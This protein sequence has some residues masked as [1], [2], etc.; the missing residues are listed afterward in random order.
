MSECVYA[1]ITCKLADKLTV[2]VINSFGNADNQVGSMLESFLNICKELFLIKCDFRKIDEN[3]V[4]AFEFTGKDT[5]TLPF[6][7]SANAAAAVSHPA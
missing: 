6:L 3:R 4:V 5:G 7:P 1:Y 2:S